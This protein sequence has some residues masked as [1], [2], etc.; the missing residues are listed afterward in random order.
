ME[1]HCT[2]AG[3]VATKIF[4]IGLK[5]FGDDV[6]FVLRYLGFL[7]SVNDENSA[8]LLMISVR[9]GAQMANLMVHRCSC[10]V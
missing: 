9:L 8:Y 3:D 4:E 7:I 5:N 2:K 1:Y 6:E 10:F